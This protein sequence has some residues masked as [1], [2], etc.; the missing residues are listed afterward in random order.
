MKFVRLDMFHNLIE[1]KKL[2]IELEFFNGFE[3]FV[4]LELFRSSYISSKSY[5]VLL[6]HR[7]KN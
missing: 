5:L 7:H 3:L 4:E 2:I 6:I 1:T